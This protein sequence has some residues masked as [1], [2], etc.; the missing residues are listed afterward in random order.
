VSKNTIRES[1]QRCIVLAG[2]NDVLVEDNIAYDTAGHCFVLQ[3]GM[4]SGNI[5]RRNLGA[6]TRKVDVVIPNN[7]SSGGESDDLPSTYFITNP[8]NTWEANV[9]AGSEGNAFGIVLQNS[10]KGLYGSEYATLD[11]S[12]LPLTLFKDNVAHS[13]RVVS[14]YKPLSI[15]LGSNVAHIYLFCREDSMSV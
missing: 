6:L 7:G 4:E 10:V 9:G 1:N 15:H 2:T 5:F 8:S 3:D 12:S 11:P 13:N 14:P